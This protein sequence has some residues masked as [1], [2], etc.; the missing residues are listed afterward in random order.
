MILST[1]SINNTCF[2]I[3][4]K[5]VQE[6]NRACIERGKLAMRSGFTL[7]EYTR[8]NKSDYDYRIGRKII[9]FH[10]IAEKLLAD[11]EKVKKAFCDAWDK[12]I[13]KKWL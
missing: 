2:G 3:S 4:T 5:T 13:S 6:A 10:D 12:V 11:K 8:M 7:E 1:K 9:N